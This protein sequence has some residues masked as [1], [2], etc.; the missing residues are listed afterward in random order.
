MRVLDDWLLTAERVA[1]HGPTAT[2]VVADL[3]LGY[4]EA[5]R[6]GGEAVPSDSL[7]EQLAGLRRVL[8]QYHVQRLVIAGDLLEDGNCRQ[9]LAAFH[10]WLKQTRVELAVV[11]GN[12]DRNLGDNGWGVD[13][14]RKVGDPQWIYPN[15]FAL[16]GWQVLH[17][18]GVIPDGPVVHGHEHPCLRWSP[19]SRAI[20]PRVFGSRIAPCAWKGLVIWSPPSV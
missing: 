18:D 8:G 6:R 14:P 12:H 10:E 17:G 9:A 19:K 1:I 7:D 16:D 15:G 11:P 2:A 3:H 4:A 5:R 20:R 13:S